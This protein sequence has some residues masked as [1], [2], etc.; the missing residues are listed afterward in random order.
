MHMTN[1]SFDQRLRRFKVRLVLTT[2]MLLALGLPA[3]AADDFVIDTPVTTT[4]GG[5]ALGNTDTL[6]VTSTGRID[7]SNS[8]VDFTSNGNIVTIQ[9]GGVIST[10]GAAANGINGLGSNFATILNDGTIQTLGPLSS[11]IVLAGTNAVVTNNGTL[12]AINGNAGIAVLGDFSVITNNGDISTNTA[13]S[14]GI[15]VVSGGSGTIVN[16]GTITV[17]GGNNQAIYTD[18]IAQQITNN[19]TL[20]VS[21][22]GGNG[23]FSDGP[24]AEINNSGTIRVTGVGGNGIHASHSQNTIT[25]SGKVISERGNAFLLKFG[26][27][28]NLL[29]PSFLG[30]VI[31][32]SGNP[33]LTVNIA[34]EKSH[35]VLW[36]FTPAE[37]IGGAPNISG[38]MPWFYNTTSGQFATY[39]PTVLAASADQFALLSGLVSDLNSPLKQREGLWIEAFGGFSER[40]GDSQTFDRTLGLGGAAVGGSLSLEEAIMIGG[41]IGYAASSM[42]TSGGYK[43]SWDN[44][45]DG[46]F[47]NLNGQYDFGP[48][49]LGL[50]LSGGYTSHS[51]KRFVNDNLALTNG[52]TI[53]ESRVKSEFGSWWVSPEATISGKIE[54][55]EDVILTPSAR[56]RY[57]LE[58][59]D[60]HTEKG[61]NA[62]ATIGRRQVDLGEVKLELAATKIFGNHS[63]TLRGGYVGQ[64]T[65]GDIKNNVSLFGQ[66]KSLSVSGFE[67]H[68]GYL[69]A[70]LQFA[71]NE[72]THIQASGKATFTGSGAGIAAALRLVRGL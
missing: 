14:V 10:N 23:I 50:G 48:L 13:N 53:G 40:D 9:S 38:T 63:A 64:T 43:T 58:I 34:T 25:N 24:H 37:I 41:S 46:I 31:N 67:R 20:M 2:S 21:G 16:N 39:D 71:V 36:H 59:F 5:N 60:S 42:N 62:N 15:S 33:G 22:P 6:T 47:A 44:R 65:F 55:K 11:A 29:S 4:N 56:V 30:G 7:T 54:L 66:K 32:T 19:G 61:G 72:K 35:S 68:E 45:G 1:S 52:L 28:L 70:D 26:G 17:S 49:Q 18:F 12:E 3:Q 51:G 27:Q 8:G 57:G 69:G